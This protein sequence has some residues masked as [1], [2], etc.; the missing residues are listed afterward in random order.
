M[1]CIKLPYKSL[2]NIINKISVKLG[3]Q[4]KEIKKGEMIC[5]GMPKF[6]V[7][8]VDRAKPKCPW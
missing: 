6:M 4:M 3:T 2:Y 5:K 7:S 1:F 8:F